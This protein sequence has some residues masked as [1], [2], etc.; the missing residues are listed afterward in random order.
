MSKSKHSLQLTAV[1]RMTKTLRRVGQQF[2][3]LSK[4]I[5]KTNADLYMSKKR[6][7]AFSKSMGRIGGKMG[8][9]GKSMNRNI[10]L[11]VAAL[12]ALSIKLSVD[13]ARSMNKVEMLTGA[14]GDSFDALR[15]QAK[16]LGASTKFSAGESAEAMAFLGMAGWDTQKIMKGLPAVLDLAAASG[17]GLAQSADIASNIM[18]AFAIPAENASRVADVL[19]RTTSSANVDMTMLAETMK[20]AGPVA[21]KFSVSLEDTASLAS[22]LGKVGIQGGEAGTAI[23]N[24]M[25][26]IAAPGGKARKILGALGVEVSG[27]D[28][29]LRKFTDIMSDMGTSMEGLDQADKMAAMKQIFGKLSI[30][31]ASELLDQISVVGKDGLT[32]FD[33]LSAKVNDTNKT[34]KTMAKTFQKGAPGA[35]DKMKSAFEGLMIAI[36]HSGVIEIFTKIVLKVTE[37]LSAASKN[38]ALI[39][40]GVILGIVAAGIGVVISVLAKVALIIPFL[41]KGFAIFVTVLKFVGTIAAAIATGVSLPF[42]AIG[43]AIAAAAALVWRYWDPIVKM[44]SKVKAGISSIG[45]GIKGFFGFGGASGENTK[46]NAA[47]NNINE[48]KT[49]SESTVLLKTEQGV[50]AIPKGPMSG[51]SLQT[52]MAGG[53]F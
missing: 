46:S 25:L 17:T 3:K 38:K 22:L 2:P 23:K 35:V 1:D 6:T 39:K 40:F 50:T 44:F 16:A 10:G 53:S 43:V 48:S 19:A 41:V 36:G 4:A 32:G 52:G 21:K 28:G 47:Q 20:K 26:G 24:A 31:G 34:A 5:R 27:S 51:I 42:I 29:K 49:T 37:F 9:V 13:F 15:N 33:K 12:G 30:A 7:A 11:P 14:T 8:K 18:G 45:G